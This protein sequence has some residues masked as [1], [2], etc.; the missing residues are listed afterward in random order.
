[1]VY[2]LHVFS[3]KGF[4]AFLYFVKGIL[5][6]RLNV[7]RLLEIQGIAFP[8]VTGMSPYSCDTW[9][10]AWAIIATMKG[11]SNLTVI[12]E[13]G[14]QPLLDAEEEAAYFGPLKQ[15]QQVANYEVRLNWE[16]KSWERDLESGP[17]RITRP[18]LPS[19]IH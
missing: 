4:E 1:M 10:Q 17:Y 8:F 14:N 15:I 13:P 3:F 6:E 11:L 7:I 2:K 12:I 16:K 5:P 19:P 18:I 9:T